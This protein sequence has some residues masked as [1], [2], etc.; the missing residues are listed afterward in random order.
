MYSF[1]IVHCCVCDIEN[2][3]VNVLLEYFIVIV[4]KMLLPCGLPPE[5]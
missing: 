2:G 4:Q 3:M 1:T 5:K